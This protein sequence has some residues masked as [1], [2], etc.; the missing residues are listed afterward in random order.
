[1]VRIGTLCQ[2][3]AGIQSGNRICVNFETAELVWI[4]YGAGYLLKTCSM[5]W[6]NINKIYSKYYS[7]PCLKTE[8]YFRILIDGGECFV[9]LLSYSEVR[10]MSV[11]KGDK[12]DIWVTVVD[13]SGACV[14]ELNSSIVLRSWSVASAPF[15]QNNIGVIFVMIL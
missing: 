1:M 4:I 10:I 14:E 7:C 6:R 13:M 11:I 2:F 12:G 5:S 15:I 8:Q 3:V 9:C